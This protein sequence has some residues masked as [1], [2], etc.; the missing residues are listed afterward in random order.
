L[1]SACTNAEPIFRSSPVQGSL[2]VALPG[3]STV[4]VQRRRRPRLRLRPIPPATHRRWCGC[5]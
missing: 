1:R 2:T 5:L 3:P 4:G